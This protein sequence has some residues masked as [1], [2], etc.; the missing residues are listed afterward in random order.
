MRYIL[1][2]FMGI[3]DMSILSF[4]KQVLYLKRLWIYRLCRYL[5]WVCKLST[6][7]VF[8]NKESVWLAVII[9]RIS[10]VVIID[11]NIFN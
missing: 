2:I 7:Y 4:T 5:V 11:C 3:H 9:G 8:V 1:E 10:A 6:E